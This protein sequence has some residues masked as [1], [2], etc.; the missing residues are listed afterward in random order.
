METGNSSSYLEIIHHPPTP[1]TTKKKALGFIVWHWNF[2]IYLEM[3]SFYLDNSFL[4]KVDF[5]NGDSWWL[6]WKSTE[7]SRNGMSDTL[8]KQYMN[9]VRLA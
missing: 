7:H 8:H 2:S 5:E 9:A 4:G 3:T 1:P 6:L